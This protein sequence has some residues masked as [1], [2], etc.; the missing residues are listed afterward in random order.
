MDAESSV[1]AGDGAIEL[2][3]EELLAELQRMV[4][5]LEQGDLPL[6]QSLAM[7]EQGVRLSRLASNRLDEADRRVELLLSS[8]DGVRTRVLQNGREGGPT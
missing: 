6:E 1:V 2:P 8:E 7:F 4:E 3:F 5:R